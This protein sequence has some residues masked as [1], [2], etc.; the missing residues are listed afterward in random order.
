MEWRA[1]IN[2]ITHTSR[3]DCS[4]ASLTR[5]N[6]GKWSRTTLENGTGGVEEQDRRLPLL[7]GKAR[8]F[9][10]IILSRWGGDGL[11][12]ENHN[13]NSSLRHMKRTFMR[14]DEMDGELIKGRR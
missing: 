12:H 13:G 10:G 2:F 7:T 3:F 11:R 8:V 4:C 14:L 1:S 9:P 6:Y 5:F